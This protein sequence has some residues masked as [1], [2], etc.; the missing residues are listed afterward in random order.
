MERH[1]RVGILSILLS[2]SGAAS[3]APGDLDPTF[4]EDG[5]V[6]FGLGDDSSLSPSDMLIQP[7]DKIVIAGLTPSLGSEAVRDVVVARFNS[8][9]TLDTT[10]NRVGYKLLPAPLGNATIGGP[11][12]RQSDGKLIV[13]ATASVAAGDRDFLLVRLQPDGSIDTS[14]GTEGATTV[15]FGSGL[16]HVFRVAVQ[17]DGRIVIAGT[18]NAGGVSDFAAARLMASGSLDP[19][20]GAQGRVILDSGLDT[21]DVL[22]GLVV[23]SDG[24]IVLAAALGHSR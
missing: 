22:N 6:F 11:I 8:D 24:R 9:G 4:G 18:A 15:S 7:D 17:P 20:F 2:V 19:S 10:F 1:I 12:A 14:F 21:T 3:A 13:T 5:R 16:D 23:Q